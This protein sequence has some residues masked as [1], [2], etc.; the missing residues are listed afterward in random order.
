MFSVDAIYDLTPRF[1]LGGK[2]GYRFGELRDV[3]I[4]N[5]QTFD[6][7][8][9][10]AIIRGDYHIVRAWDV[11]GEL[12][13]LDADEAGDARAGA[14]VAVYRHVNDNFK[15]G[16]GY[17]FTDFSDDLTDLDYSSDGPFLNLLGKF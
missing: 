17:N 3:T 10:L 15:V 2:F 1:A 14:L 13:Y 6:S 8:A 12:R 4:A 11:V 7:Q 9:W 5:S 16:V